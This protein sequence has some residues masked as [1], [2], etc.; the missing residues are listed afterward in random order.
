[1]DLHRLRYFVTIAKARHITRAAAQLG[2]Q[3]APLSQQIKVLEQEIGAQLF[4]RKPRGVEL[5]EAGQTLLGYAQRILEEVERAAV[6]TRQVGEGA[7]GALRI[8]LT[9]SASFHPFPANAIRAY[10]LAYR[11]VTLEL[12]HGSSPDLIQKLQSLEIHLAFARTT[13]RV[14]PD[15][16]VEH[17]LEEPMVAALP[18]T[19]RLAQS[20]SSEML[21]LKDLATDVFVAYPHGPG[22]GLYDALLSACRANGFTPII[23]YEAPQ[24][25]GTLS[26]VGAG[27]GVTI[28]PQSLTMIR[29]DNVVFREIAVPRKGRAH[30][31][32]VMLKRADEAAIT[33][34]REIVLN[35]SQNQMDGEQ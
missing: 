23:G 24:M 6:A 13:L 15:L 1:M 19:H 25:I 35:L 5:T 12:Y 2:I 27:L 9:S 3:Q 16:R 21:R 8:G 32:L 30:L 22:A 29:M 4:I 10:R 18:A 26:L 11:D 14:P 17:L 31:N 7:T 33:A 28:V 34:F 20:S